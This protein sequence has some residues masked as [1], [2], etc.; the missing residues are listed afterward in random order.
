MHIQDY[1]IDAL[2]GLGLMGEGNIS[3]LVKKT[4]R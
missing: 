4:E 2:F 1:E 3:R